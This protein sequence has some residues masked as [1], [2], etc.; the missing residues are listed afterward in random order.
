MS[1]PMR[2]GGQGGGAQP[3]VSICD[4]ERRATQPAALSTD[5]CICRLDHRGTDVETVAGKELVMR[6][7]VF[8][9]AR[10]HLPRAVRQLADMISMVLV[11]DMEDN[12]P[13]ERITAVG[14]RLGHGKRKEA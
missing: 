6:V 11:E 10:R 12:P 13:H 7:Y 5:T 14:E 2:P 4:P 8:L 9:L 3:C 1:G